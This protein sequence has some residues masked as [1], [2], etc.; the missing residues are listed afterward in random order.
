MRFRV[1]G[2]LEISSGDTTIRIP[3]AKQRI[4]LAALLCQPNRTVSVSALTDAVWSDQPPARSRVVLQGY[5]MRIRKALATFGEPQDR[6]ETVAPGYRMTV[7]ENE[8]DTA[9][10]DAAL[11]D[12]DLALGR[13]DIAAHADH[14]QDALALWRG[15]A[16]M[17]I[18]SDTLQST[19][20][21]RLAELR[22]MAVEKLID[23]YLTLGRHSAAAVELRQHIARNPLH[24]RFYGQLMIALDRTGRRAAALEVYRQV[25]ELLATEL[26]IEP[27]QEIRRLGDAILR[28]R[29]ISSMTRLSLGA[30]RQ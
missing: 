5:I 26:G 20:A 1:L 10:F 22:I 30:R 3:A 12:A 28:G 16:L 23:A 25:N 21:H 13:G 9:T 6:I 11:L 15:P 8:L 19:E 4:V 24:E 18:E 14:L 29:A 17:D 2:P 7:A 27:D